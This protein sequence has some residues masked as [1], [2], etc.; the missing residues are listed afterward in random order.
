[1]FNLTTK[2]LSFETY[3]IDPRPSPTLSTFIVYKVYQT[4]A[5]KEKQKKTFQRIKKYNK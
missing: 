2:R 1:M 5:I 4:D 3:A